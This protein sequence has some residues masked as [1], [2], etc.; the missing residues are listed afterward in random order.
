MQ[1]T[2]MQRTDN[3]RS[4]IP[5][6]ITMPHLHRPWPTPLL[7]SL[8]VPAVGLAMILAFAPVTQAAETHG[9]GHDH[10]SAPASF[11]KP[12]TPSKA[13]RTINVDAA[14][15]MRFTPSEIRVKKGETVRFVVR[16]TGKQPHEFILGTDKTLR[17]HAAMMKQHTGMVHNDPNQITVAA[18]ATAEIVWQFAQA[19]TVAFACLVPGHMEAGMKGAVTVAN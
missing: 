14:D 7:S 6:K 3:A 9:S 16:N 19:G 10:A 13:T 17:E 18:G 8:R 11:G 15:T 12:G 1:L 5:I 4:C 2:A